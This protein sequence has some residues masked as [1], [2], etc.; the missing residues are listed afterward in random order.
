MSKKAFKAENDYSKQKGK[1]PSLWVISE[2]LKKAHA[3][4]RK[5]LKSKS[6]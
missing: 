2:G 5:D 3:K 4:I 6:K 1:P